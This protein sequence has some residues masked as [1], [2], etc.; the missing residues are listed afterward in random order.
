MSRGSPRG[1]FAGIAIALIAAV[2][3]TVVML[4]IGSR[5]PQAAIRAFFFGPFSN[6]YYLGN[7]INGFTVL[8]LTGLGAALAFRAGV[9]NLGGEGQVYIAAVVTAVTANAVTHASAPVG[10]A[11][12][13]TAGVLAAAMTAGLSGL[14]RF[15][16]DTDELITSFLIASASIPIIDYM[17]VG[18]LNDPASNLLTTPRIPE[19]L[20]LLRIL[21]PSRLHIG[22]IAALAVAAL[23][24]FLLFHTVRGY[25]WRLTGLN[26]EF[27]RYGGINTGMY[28]LV[29][30]A[31]SGALHG[32][33]GSFH[34]LGTH[35]AALVGFSAGLGWNGLAVAL[36]GRSHP[37]G[38]L[39]AAMVFAYLQ[40]GSRTA[41]LHTEFTFE[42]ATI[43][44]AVVFFIITA[45][46]LPSIAPRFTRRIG[47]RLGIRSNNGG[48]S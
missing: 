23:A 38:V 11:L 17:I 34:V 19:A 10:I 30:M 47:A 2:L 6:T 14:F 16:W 3:V 31:I 46:H 44:Q 48:E 21:P 45:Q 25:E 26:I 28:I 18:P 15:L 41:I 4:V 24:Y 29:P 33:A 8:V 13:L 5:T 1:S 36:I 32:L 27:A 9:F 12:A 35:H 22:I 20:R 37:L 7:M 42:L 43:I 39:P 40:S